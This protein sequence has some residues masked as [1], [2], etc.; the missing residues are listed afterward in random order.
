[1]PLFDPLHCVLLLHCRAIAHAALRTLTLWQGPP[2]T[3]KTRTLLALV[4][5]RSFLQRHQCA[6]TQAGPRW[7]HVYRVESSKYEV[8]SSKS[9]AVVTFVAL[10]TALD[11][12]LC[13]RAEKSP[14]CVRAPPLP[15]LP[16]APPNRCWSRRLRR[17]RGAGL[18]WV[19]SWHVVTPMQQWT[20]LW[21]DWSTRGC[22]WC[23]WDSQ[24]RC[25]VMMLLS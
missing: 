21:R 23:A 15:V 6:V 19:L 2:G 16:A 22:G 14:L 7:Q 5:V 4:E 20:T 8:T 10:H 18:P 13:S 25:A 3:G 11:V 1:L 24:Q 9:S 17:T 12:S